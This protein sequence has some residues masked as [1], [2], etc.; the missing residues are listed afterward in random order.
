MLLEEAWWLRVLRETEQGCRY[1]R[2]ARLFLIAT[3]RQRPV[4]TPGESITPIGPAAA[5][6]RHGPWERRAAWGARLKPRRPHVW[7]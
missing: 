3:A 6:A 1:A 5:E 4:G 7:M 2:W